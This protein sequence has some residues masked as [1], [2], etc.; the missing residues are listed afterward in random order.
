LTWSIDH[1]AWNA[2]VQLTSATTSVSLATGLAGGNH[3]LLTYVA[4]IFSGQDKWITPVSVVRT[5]GLTLDTGASVTALSTMLYPGDT[6]IAPGNMIVFGASSAETDALLPGG[7]GQV[8]YQD[9][10]QAYAQYL[11]YVFGCEVGLVANGG[12]GMTFAGGGNV[13]GLVTS[14]NFYDS[15]NSR[16]I[17][18]LLSP[19]PK[20]IVIDDGYNDVGLTAAV[21]A[22]FYQALAAAAPNARIIQLVYETLAP[23]AVLRA[24][25]IL[26]GLANVSVVSLGVYPINSGGST[27]FDFTNGVHLNG[28]GHTLTTA[29]IAWGAGTNVNQFQRG[30]RSPFGTA[31]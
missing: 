16:L 7:T 29:Q 24:G 8:T 15:A 17:A 6:G 2:P 25:A 18:G 14:W 5:T 23:S 11:G 1:A 3:Y 30:S 21:V 12:T 19:P 10:S 27:A 9:G 20:F 26:S 22:A 31:A 28:R 13:P 4:G